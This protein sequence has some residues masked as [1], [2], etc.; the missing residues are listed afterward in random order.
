MAIRTMQTVLTN[1]WYLP[2]PSLGQAMKTARHRLPYAVILVI[3][4]LVLA[5]CAELGEYRTDIARLRSDLHANA[6][7]LSQLSARVDELERRQAATE[8]ATRQAQQELSHAIEVLLKKALMTDKRQTS[9]ES[10][11]SQS[12][13]AEALEK[14]GRQLPSEMQRATSQGGNALQGGKP[15]SLGMTQEDVRRALGDPIS[16]E[17]AG[18][19]IFW[20]Y[21]QTSNEKYVVFEKVSGQVSGWR[22]L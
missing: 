5:S 20:Q 10:G 17:N 21:S 7:L 11:K 8:S 9:R 19:Y 12:K 22:G 2:H 13:D 18:S 16:I 1:H 15:L 4:P 6:Q 14:Q 3:A